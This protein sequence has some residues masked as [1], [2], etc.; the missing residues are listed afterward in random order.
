MV[1]DSA[2]ARNKNKVIIKRVFELFDKHSQIILVG[3]ENVGSN[4]V[5][6]I[7]KQLAKQGGQL[8]IAKNVS[9]S[10]RRRCYAT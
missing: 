1:R 3:F 7:R 8:V 5:Q 10:S 6:K 2:T 4:Q 9:L